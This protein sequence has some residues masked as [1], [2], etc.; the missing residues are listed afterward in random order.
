MD[1]FVELIKLIGG[2]LGIIA[3][4]LSVASAVFIVWDR[5]LRGRPIFALQAD[6]R[7]AGDN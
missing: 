2:I 4:I 3:T 5:V 7:V 1:T 6:P